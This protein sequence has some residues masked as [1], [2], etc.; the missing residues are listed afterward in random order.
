MMNCVIVFL[1]CSLF[2]VSFRDFFFVSL[3]NVRC[4]VL[5]RNGSMAV[6]SLDDPIMKVE[7]DIGRVN[8]GSLIMHANLTEQYQNLKRVLFVSLKKEKLQNGKAHSFN[9]FIF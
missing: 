6:S 5:N 3:F 2:I 1:V 8:E 4:H 9:I 7:A